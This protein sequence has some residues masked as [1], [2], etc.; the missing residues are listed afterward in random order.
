MKVG[1]LLPTFRPEANDALGAADEAARCGLDGVFAYD[2]LWPIGHPGRP[3]LAPFPLLAVI[4]ARE[5]GLH[6]GPLVARVGLVDTEVLVAEFHT[7]ASFAPGLVIA[8]LGT[9]DHLSAPEN[10]AYGLVA[11]S[12]DER[13]AMIVETARTLGATMP[14]WVGAGSPTTNEMARA[15]GAELNFWD[16]TPLEMAAESATSRV[17]WAGNPL[18]DLEN[19]LDEL[20]LAGA[21]WAIFSPKADL[22]R[23]G[24]WRLTN[25][26]SK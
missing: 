26:G 2:H 16:R 24:R 10:A 11:R 23:L 17:N 25:Y 7:L 21:T 8:A 1:V 6:I 19:Q 13:R 18:D 4:A 20:A 3:S 22:D 5:L 15:I 12:A 9:G 14:V